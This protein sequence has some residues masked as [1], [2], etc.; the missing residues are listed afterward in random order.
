MKNIASF[1][2]RF[3]HGLLLLAVFGWLF[4]LATA[5][6]THA[7]VPSLVNYQGKVQVGAVDFNGTGQFKFALVNDAGTTTYW[8]ND[9]TGAGGAQP[10]AAVSLAVTKGVYSLQLGDVT[11][12]NMTA[13]PT[14]V[15][16]NPDV[17]LRVWFND[18]ANGFQQL[19]PD[20]RIVAVGYAM[21]AGTVPDGSITPNKLA[22]TP[23]LSI[24]VL[25][26]MHVKGINTNP[27]PAQM[28][29]SMSFSVNGTVQSAANVTIVKMA[30][31]QFEFTETSNGT[32]PFTTST[33][34]NKKVSQLVVRRPVT[35]DGAWRLWATKSTL[36]DEVYKTV[37]LQFDSGPAI[38][39]ENTF[40]V[41]YR[42][43][44]GTDGI[45]YETLTL[46]PQGYAIQ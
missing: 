26:E 27:P 28:V 25:G 4:A 2:S 8:S 13:L 17:R 11:L 37:T 12:A 10:A 39:L 1:P 6:E 19:T 3:P 30:E 36:S 22:A 5:T 45:F 16:N 14:N 43:E 29:G 38:S 35:S 18:G 21:V 44:Q 20:Q 24:S 40:V 32:D 46:K 9:G 23:T 31:D 33:P 42:V 15:F 7:Q 34:L 41:G